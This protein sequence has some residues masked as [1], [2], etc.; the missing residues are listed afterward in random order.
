MYLRGVIHINLS[1]QM[2]RNSI[3]ILIDINNVSSAEAY[4][5]RSAVAGRVG[6]NRKTITKASPIIYKNWMIIETEL[7]T[8]KMGRAL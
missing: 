6:C 8:A 5:T 3:F 2:S 7:N 1:T 4:T